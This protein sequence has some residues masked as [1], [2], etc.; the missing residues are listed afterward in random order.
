MYYLAPGP[1]TGVHLSQLAAWLVIGFAIALRANVSSA[2]RGAVK[3]LVAVLVCG[4][5]GSTDTLLLYG[6]FGV[7]PIA[8][9]PALIASAIALHLTLRTNLLLPQGLDRDVAIEL[10]SF[11]TVGVV[12]GALALVVHGSS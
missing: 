3:L 6:V 11:A 8:W 10:V 12:I 5:I 1:L 9:L 7:Y 2:Q 4:A